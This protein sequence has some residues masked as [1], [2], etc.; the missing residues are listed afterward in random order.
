MKQVVKRKASRLW[1]DVH[2]W[3]GLKLSLFLSFV[4]ITGTIAVLSNELD[5]LTHDS[6]RVA[7]QP[8]TERASWGEIYE[9]LKNTYPDWQFSYLREP[10]DPW[11]TVLAYG[12]TP[13]V[14]TR[15]IDVDPYTA[16]VKGDRHW[17]S[18]QRF[19]RNSHRHLML[20]TRI[21]V[22]IV[23]A[24][25]FLMIASMIT[26]LVVYKKFWRGF[27]KMP[28]R[29]NPRI[30]NGDLHRLLG[31]WSF[32]FLPVI[33]LTS[34]FYFAESLGWRAPPF[35]KP[36]KATPIDSNLDGEQI[37]VY[38][39]RALQALPGLR[40]A[41][42]LPPTKA[43]DSLVFQGY[44]DNT[45]LVRAR[46]SYVAMDPADGRVL[47]AHRSKDA[48]LHQRIAEMADPLHFGTFGGITT[49]LIWFVFGAILSALA[50]TGVVIYAKRLHK[51][52]FPADAAQAQSAGPWV[53][54]WSGM[55]KWKWIGVLAI[56]IVI[57][58]TPIEAGLL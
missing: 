49:K 58:L 57:A 10:V 9:S 43:G 1:F 15:L 45:W 23:S 17:M 41:L 26:G 55:G 51:S 12:R 3:V 33:A 39:Q 48:N 13:D 28:R 36:E 37:D 53:I 18:F 27:F 20:P 46:A 19:F 50:V 32:W 11:F 22:P 30:F 54:T 31:L 35:G 5:W 14:H 21:G 42:V 29:R 2:S 44:T 34:V 52:Y 47:G 6:M 40:I 8:A 24:L 16:K 56:G 25:A 38:A 4:L 7:P